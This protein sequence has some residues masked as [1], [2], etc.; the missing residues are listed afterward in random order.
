VGEALSGTE[1]VRQ[2]RREVADAEVAELSEALAEAVLAEREAIAHA[3]AVRAR[4]REAQASL[5][6]L[7]DSGADE[8]PADTAT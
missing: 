7:D 1:H 3:G 5:A 6:E 8:P 4:L 2:F